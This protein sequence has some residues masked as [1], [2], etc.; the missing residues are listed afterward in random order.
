MRN[1]Q[2]SAVSRFC[3]YDES[4]AD[5][6]LHENLHSARWYTKYTNRVGV[7]LLDC[8]IVYITGEELYGK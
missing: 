2:I 5:S 8:L 7:S 1:M 6:C 3:V 4:S